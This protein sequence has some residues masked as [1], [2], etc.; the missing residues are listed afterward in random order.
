M[1]FGLESL[2]ELKEYTISKARA[3]G[4]SKASAKSNGTI[5]EV[6]IRPKTMVEFVHDEQSFRMW[7]GRYPRGYVL[8]DS[9]AD[10]FVLHF[11]S[12][13]HLYNEKPEARLSGK[14]KFCAEDKHEVIQY[15]FTERGKS[16][17]R[18]KT[19]NP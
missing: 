9:A 11:G 19:C 5:A 18:C 14:G 8:N 15:A 3:A 13:P 1:I 6:V 4:H 12:C 10:G 7:T 16:P 17:V 2:A